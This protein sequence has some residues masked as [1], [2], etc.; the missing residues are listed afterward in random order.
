MPTYIGLASWTSEGMKTVR[1]TIK[2]GEDTAALLR[3]L[4]GEL[5]A[6]YWTSGPYDIVAI[7]DVPD[8]ETLAKLAL[9]IT[10]RGTTRFTAVR[11]FSEDEMVRILAQLPKPATAS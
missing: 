7:A 10:S 9:T 8:E 4:G 5:K 11:A 2:R 6:T 1:E 3:Q